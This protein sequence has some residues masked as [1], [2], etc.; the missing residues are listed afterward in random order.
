M[1]KEQQNRRKFIQSLGLLTI[2]FSMSAVAC[3]RVKSSRAVAAA[4]APDP[5]PA[6]R[7]ALV[8]SEQ[9]DSWLVIREDGRVIIYTGKLELGQGITTAVAQVA[10]EELNMD[11]AGID[12]ELAQT[13]YTPNEGYTSGSRSIE[14][15]AMSIRQAAASARELLL[16]LAAAHFA[17]EKDS[18][19]IENG[20]ILS[21]RQSI[22]MYALLEG[23]QFSRGI[24]PDVP[25]YGRSRRKLVGQAVPRQDIKAI[26]T[27]KLHF[28]H[29][30]RFDKMV[31]ARVI[32]PPAPGAKL[33]AVNESAI[34]GLPGLTKWVRI[35]SFVAVIAHDEYRAIQLTDQVSEY[36]EWQ[37]EQTLPAGDRLQDYIKTLTRSSAVDKQSE[38]WSADLPAGAPVYHRA[39]YAKPYTMHASNGPSCAVARY[40]GGKLWVWSHSQGVYPLRGAIAGLVGLQ[41]EQVHVKGVPGAGCYGHNGADDAAAEAA[42]LAM[43]FPDRHIRL[44]WMREDEHVWEPYGTTMAVT[45]AAGLDKQ[46]RIQSWKYQLWSDD[47]GVR[48]GG[49]ANKL[50]PAWYIAKGYELP[51]GGGRGGA[52]RNAEPYYHIPQLQL[53]S[54]LFRGP[55][56]RSSLR[57]LGAY[58][59]VFA[60]ESFM[61]ELAE[62]AGMEPIAFRL[63]HLND[64][65]ASDCLR[66]LQ[67]K[68]P[69]V[70]RDESQGIG[71]AFARYK[72]TAAYC[73]VAI[74]VRMDTTGEDVQ[75][76]QA[77]CVVDTGEVINS[78]GVKNQIEGG[79][80]QSISWGLLEEVTFDATQVTSRDWNSYP[81]LRFQDAPAVEV[82]LIDRPDQPVL[83]AGEAAQ[84]PATAALANAIYH[85]SGKRVRNLPIRKYLASITNK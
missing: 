18:L 59:N 77:W 24:L 53:S 38:G 35:G 67:K 84:G 66:M 9:I 31:H 71:I 82:E 75:V 27:G 7:N 17:V 76:I 40:A 15:S 22:A 68:I 60:I 81:V 4:V 8:D 50:L 49:D 1:Q 55:L 58:A 32:R 62:K 36:L 57:A 23:K 52:V 2:G 26:L 61:D 46:G 19:S 78:D 37:Y 41:E 28:I 70:E 11:M 16:E 44:Q 34:Q 42:L 5:A 54:H 85:A 83:G 73:A 47:H 39:E 12:V 14:T 51:A 21:G 29:D 72:N 20:R 10:A 13:G 64:T 80:I 3:R 63:L 43:E 74:Q 33:V 30:L 6:L 56:R 65:R 25:I 48:P 45:I 69:V 79:I